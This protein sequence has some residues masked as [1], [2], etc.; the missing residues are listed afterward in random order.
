MFVAMPIDY[1]VHSGVA[2]ATC[3][4]VVTGRDIRDLI[5]RYVDDSRL[6]V[7]HRELFDVGH[8][9]SFDV[10]GDDVRMVVD[11]VRSTGDRF[12]GAKVAYVAAGDMPYGIGRMFGAYAENLDIKLR[13][14]RDINDAREWLG[15]TADDAEDAAPGEG[16]GDR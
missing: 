13:V 12:R 11:F 1:E 10:G 6:S 4:G 7:P 9:E 16:Q 15:L 8:A 2:I 5:A 3:R 14:F